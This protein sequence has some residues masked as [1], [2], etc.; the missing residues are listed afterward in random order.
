M[1]AHHAPQTSRHFK[2]I[3]DCENTVVLPWSS[4]GGDGGSFMVAEV[5]TFA[6]KPGWKPGVS[7]P[8]RKLPASISVH[9]LVLVNPS[10]HVYHSSPKRKAF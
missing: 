4:V 8:Q 3:F 2:G 7:R 1:T 5:V 6:V 9:T 10:Y